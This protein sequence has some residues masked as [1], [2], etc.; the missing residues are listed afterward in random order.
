MGTEEANPEE[1]R[2]PEPDWLT[3]PTV[4]GK[5]DFSGRGELSGSLHEQLSMAQHQ[6]A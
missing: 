1:K 3:A 6:V 4:H 2:L 5:A